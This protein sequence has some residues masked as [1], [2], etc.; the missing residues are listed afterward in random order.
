MEQLYS[1]EETYP[2]RQVQTVYKGPGSKT[3]RGISW[4]NNHINYNHLLAEAKDAQRYNH[5]LPWLGSYITKVKAQKS[6]SQ[7]VF[8]NFLS[9]RVQQILLLT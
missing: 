4:T 1:W 7:S 3:N 2:R 9:E 8:L 5:L 6:H